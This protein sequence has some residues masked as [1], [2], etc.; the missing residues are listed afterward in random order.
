MKFHRESALTLLL[1]AL[2]C[3][4][5]CREIVA[6]QPEMP[7]VIAYQID[8]ES[9][10]LSEPGNYPI[11]ILRRLGRSL[12]SQWQGPNVTLLA[13]SLFDASKI[14]G[15]EFLKPL[16]DLQLSSAQKSAASA[17][18][19][20]RQ[21]ELQEIVDSCKPASQALVI[22]A[23]C[24]SASLKKA[25]SESAEK[26]GKRSGSAA[27]IER[28]QA[29]LMPILDA[30]DYLAAA[31]VISQNGCFGRLK[32]ISGKKQL[33]TDKIEH[34]ISI[35]KYINEDSLM[36]FCQTHPIEN[37]AEAFKQLTSVPQSATVVNMVASAGIDFEKDIL[38]NTARESILYVNLE[39]SGDGG[40]PDIRFVAPVPHIDKLRGNLDKFKTLCQQTGIFAQGLS[41][42]FPMVKL[43]YFMLPQA[44][45]YAGLCDR[46]LV[47][48][49]SEANLVKELA[50][51]KAVESGT[52]AQQPFSE[53][54]K[55]FWKIRTSDFNLQ[56]QKLLHSP[57]MAQ[58][59]IPPVTNLTFLEDIEHFVVKSYASSAAIEFALEIPL[60]A[61]PAKEKR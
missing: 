47:M 41:G 30:S 34:D 39:P 17:M 40:I 10:F 2:F 44:A 29:E 61:T 13:A 36:F 26:S 11:E 57:I 28:A 35:G 22:R 52:K 1:V 19:L 6:Q 25:L 50:H 4:A 54:L 49:S 14:G 45:V 51:I 60:K 23:I 42:E 9:D 55:R 21:K 38:A 33:A 59:G 56:L 15:P 37:P 5:F 16:T 20:L 46:F 3:I 18:L 32:I 27:A 8:R 31:L 7:V 53:K 24:E 43:S 58:Q 12:N 48:A